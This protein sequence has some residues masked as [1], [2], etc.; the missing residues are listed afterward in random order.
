MNLQNG[1]EIKAKIMII[2]AMSIFGT[3]GIFI[4]NIPFSS[5]MI[6][7]V[8]GLVG[9]GF[10]YVFTFIKKGNISWISV[11]N[12]IKILIW[13]GIFI[14]INWIFL[15]EAYRYT[16]V[17]TATLCYY[18]APVFIILMSPLFLKEE[19][20]IKKLICTFIALIGMFFVSGVFKGGVDMYQIKGIFYGIAAA[21]LYA[22]VIILNKKL[23]NI[24]AYDMT[25]VQLLIAGMTVLPYAA[26]SGGIIEGTVSTTGI[27]LL[28]VVSI[29]H[30]GIN[31]A[32]Y[33]GAIKNLKVQ[34]A[35]IFSYIDPVVAIFLSNWILKEKMDLYGVIGAVLILGAT[36]VSEMK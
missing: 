16:T 14:G 32:V 19:L 7:A 13:S 11:K 25:I 9:A 34:T 21:L 1:E 3:I 27:V 6:A 8:R 5:A 12:N 15:F 2:L 4:R 36:F 17:A 29:I 31:Y 28:V 22:G 18:L 20:T 26:L 10:L 33:F 30:T 23:K 24:D 35:A